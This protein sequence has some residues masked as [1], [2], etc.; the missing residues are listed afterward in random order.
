MQLTLNFEDE[1]ITQGLR[2]LFINI[3]WIFLIAFGALHACIAFSD[4][5][6]LKLKLR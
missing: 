5:Y 4:Q 3:V 6:A 1:G 2:F